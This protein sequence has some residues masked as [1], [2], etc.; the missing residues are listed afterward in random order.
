[1]VVDDHAVVRQGLRTYLDGISDVR[2]VDEASDGREALDLL[3]VLSAHDQ[4]P[5]VV[6]MDLKMPRLDGVTA[7][8]EIVARF[9]AVKVVVL[10]SFGEVRRVQAALEAGAAGYVLKDAAP[11]EIDAAVR[12]AMAGQ[13]HLDP[14]VTRRLTQRMV[15]AD[16]QLALLTRRE[17]DILALVATGLSNQE[18]AEHLMISERT[19]R[20][21]VSNLLG[22]LHLKSR[23]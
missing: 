2:M 3:G 15:S 1:M 10:T 21:H 7:T 12:T 14:V 23:T 20:T 4:L 22:K 17:R 8:V 9:P 19:A 18:I 5:D 13:V 6:L 11:E 16:D